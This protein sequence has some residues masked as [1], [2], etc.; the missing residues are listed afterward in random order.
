MATVR[1]KEKVWEN[2][3]G[4]AEFCTPPPTNLDNEL[5]LE[6]MKEMIVKPCC[7][8]LDAGSAFIWAS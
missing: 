8:I 6:L 5:D 7:D 4:H 3:L 1:A 2:T